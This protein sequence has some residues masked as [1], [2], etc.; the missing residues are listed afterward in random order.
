MRPARIGAFQ[1]HERG[2][3]ILHTDQGRVH[4]MK[5]DYPRLLGVMLMDA[6]K[7]SV[8]TMLALVLMSARRLGIVTVA[9][10]QSVCPIRGARKK[11]KP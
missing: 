9:Q 2:G 5:S 11:R 7:R 1:P 8:T 3:V 10:A 6:S 4:I